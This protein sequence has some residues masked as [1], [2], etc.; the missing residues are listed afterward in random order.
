[1]LC[2]AGSDE[3]SSEWSPSSPCRYEKYDSDMKKKGT[4]ASGDAFTEELEEL[5]AEVEKLTA[6]A[7]E[8]AQESNR[9]AVASKNAEI[10][11]EGLCR[12]KA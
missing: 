9:A 7:A 6:I 2:S 3:V 10:R 4:S 5:E 11:C 12:W 1:V 8:V